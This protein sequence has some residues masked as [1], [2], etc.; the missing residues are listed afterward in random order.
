[1]LVEIF[2]RETKKAAIFVFFKVTCVI[3]REIGSNMTFIFQKCYDYDFSIHI[4]DRRG[5]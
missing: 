2:S 4:F 5:I 3:F 1:M